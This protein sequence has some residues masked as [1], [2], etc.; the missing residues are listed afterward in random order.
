MEKIWFIL[1]TFES[2]G[3]TKVKHGLL[4]GLNPR[5]ELKRLIEDVSKLDEGYTLD[6]YQKCAGLS[7]V[8]RILLDIREKK[9]NIHQPIKI[10]YFNSV[11][12]ELGVSY[13]HL[14]NILLLLINKDV[15]KK[16]GSAYFITTKLIEDMEK[17]IAYI[18]AIVYYFSFKKVAY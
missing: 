9:I 15:I 8:V 1:Y 5:I 2:D 16:S 14:S 6:L 7:F 10:A 12:K 18:L 13:S 11:A 3:V 17:F 4:S